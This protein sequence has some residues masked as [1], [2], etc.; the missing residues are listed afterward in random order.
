MQLTDTEHFATIIANDLDPAGGKAVVENFA[1]QSAQ[2]FGNE[3][4]HAGYKDIP[5]AYLLCNNDRAGPPEFQ[6]RMIAQME[7]AAGGRK[8]AVTIVD[9]DH[10]INISHPDALAEWIINLAQAQHDS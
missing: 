10:C 2:S 9:S 7:E 3:L 8:V 5:S 1:K 6:R 4:T